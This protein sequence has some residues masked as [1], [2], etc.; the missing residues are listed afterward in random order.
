MRSRLPAIVVLCTIWPSFAAAQ[1]APTERISRVQRV[2]V[3]TL[4]EGLPDLPVETWLRS[5]I[6]A[7]ATFERTSGSCAGQRDRES[8]AV[9]LCAIVAA[10][11]ADLTV[12]IGV[13]LGEYL[14]GEKVDRW[15]TP[16]VD[17]AF[18]SR[19]RQL[20]MLN[21]LRDLPRMLSM[22]PQEW[23]REDVALESIRCLPERPQPQEDVTCAIRVVNQGRAPSFARV[24]LEVQPD[25]SRGG[26][27]IVQLR[28]G[29]SK[30]ARMT[31]PWPGEARASVV[32]GAELNGR[33][34]YHQV[35]ERG[36]LTLTRGED[37][38]TPGF[39]L[40]WVDDDQA[41]QTILSAR[42]PAGGRPQIIDV[43][44]DSSISH[45]LVSV[46][47][48]PGVT[49]TLRR[50]GGARAGAIDGDVRISDLQT[51]DLVR[52]IRAD[53]RL[54][55]I[56]RPQSGVWHIEINGTPVAGAS[57]V[58]V[59]A[60]GVSA[61]AFNDFRFV[62]KQEGV[63]GG[64]FSIDGMPLANAPATAIGRLWSGLD[65][66]TFQLVGEDGSTLRTVAL[67]KG[68]PD[69]ATDDFLGTFDLPVVP[70]HVVATAVD[71]SGARIQ[72]QYP[73]TFRAQSVALFFDYGRSDAVAR[74][75]KRRF[76]IAVT[77]LG[78]EAATFTLDVTTTVGD[79]LDLSP[80][81]LTVE[82]GTSATPS[83]TLAIPATADDVYPELR[84]TATNILDASLKN[85][86]VARLEIARDGDLDHD[87]VDD[88]QDNCRD[89][90]NADQIDMN[91]NGVGDACDPAN[92]ESI[93]IRGLSPQSGPPGSVVKIVGSG[94]GA[95]APHVVVFNG[96][97][98]AAAV[99]GA[100]ELTMTVPPDASAGPVVVFV[101][102]G[103]AIAMSPVPF[104]VR[105][106]AP[107]P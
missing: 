54:Y 98:V 65:A 59:K 26:G 89:V 17:Q 47:F 69:A 30:T 43:P 92:G 66:A 44:A 4:D 51:M 60:S 23:P 29:E 88:K 96:R 45:L 55:T 42:V 97:P 21:R 94:F 2:S 64:Y 28:A 7:A 73:G 19:G 107:R 38:D 18:I 15:D 76:S 20:V 74:G 11:D 82:P 86:A 46:E 77:N 32:A 104:I 85:S 71:P 53:L 50:P 33:T 25:R 61:L 93:A 81:P 52:N 56:A 102:A 6:G 106:A 9:P 5:V 41:P 67:R 105:P 75:T 72:R 91:R 49:T 37:L 57:A 68:D 36:A 16:R 34:P 3:S 100:N 39:L 35:N 12:T 95:A 62:R 24:F 90:P 83:F 40:G 48:L 13:R 103:K 70:F 14:Q 80:A 8:P 87:L 22:P 79:I 58:Q 101:S 31:F 10:T 99:T 63:H 78:Y 1:D 84:M 27:G